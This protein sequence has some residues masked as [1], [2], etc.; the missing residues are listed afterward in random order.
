MKT[1]LL[2]LCEQDFQ[3]ISNEQKQVILKN[4]NSNVGLVLK[5]HDITQLIELFDEARV[6][7]EA[8]SIIYDF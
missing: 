4:R 8:F 6:M 1:V 7:K 5:K 2:G 3:K